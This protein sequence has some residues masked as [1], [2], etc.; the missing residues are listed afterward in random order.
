M[1][2]VIGLF[3][4]NDACFYLYCIV[5]FKMNI[6]LNISVGHAVLWFSKY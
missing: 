4:I 1:E 2:T 5:L 6:T 3:N